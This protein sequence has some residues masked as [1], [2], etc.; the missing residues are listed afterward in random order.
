M[1]RVLKLMALALVF[2]RDRA[3]GGVRDR[4]RSVSCPD[5]P[6]NLVGDIPTRGF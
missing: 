6:D 2:V 4:S 3:R 1:S 5:G